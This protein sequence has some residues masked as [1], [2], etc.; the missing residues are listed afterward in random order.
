MEKA[1]SNSRKTISLEGNVFLELPK[2]NAP[3]RNNGASRIQGLSS[4]YF[5]DS[6]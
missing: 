1:V 5:S 6:I 2:S 4:L 3:L